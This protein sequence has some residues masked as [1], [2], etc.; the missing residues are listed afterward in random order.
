MLFFPKVKAQSQGYG[1]LERTPF[2]HCINKNIANISFPVSHLSNTSLVSKAKFITVLIIQFTTLVVI[3][4]TTSL[5]SS[6]I[7]EPETVAKHKHILNYKKIF[8][9]K[10][11]AFKLRV[12][13]QSSYVTPGFKPF[14][15][16]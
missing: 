10:F 5:I 3:K 14:S 13:V 6:M 16:S 7:F 8:S 11:R 12:T 1:V 15:F 4:V 9:P 2:F